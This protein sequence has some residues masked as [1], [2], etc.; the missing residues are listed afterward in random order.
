MDVA[1]TMR[2]HHHSIGAKPTKCP[3]C[4]HTHLTKLTQ[5]HIDEQ[6]KK[7]VG[8]EMT[9]KLMHT[10]LM[11]LRV[12]PHLFRMLITENQ[13]NKKTDSRSTDI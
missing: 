2:M 7:R 12:E 11:T 6:K 4:C 1:C 10:G 5:T 9:Q 13:Y 8:P 3:A